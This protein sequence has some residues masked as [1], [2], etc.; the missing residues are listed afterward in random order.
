MS[1]LLFNQ[2]T[3]E[4]VT[5]MVVATKCDLD[6]KRIVS[7]LEGQALAEALNLPFMEASAEKNLGVSEVLVP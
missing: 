1:I 5:K 2:Q 6:G 4:G 3:S 7:T